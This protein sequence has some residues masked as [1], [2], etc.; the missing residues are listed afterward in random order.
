MTVSVQRNIYDLGRRCLGILA[1]GFAA[2]SC[3]GSDGAA[4]P[5]GPAG[6]AGAA[7]AAGA[8][9]QNCTVA[10]NGDGTYDV[11]CGGT[12]VTL[13]DGSAG[14]GCMITDNGDGTHLVSC[15]ADT[16][17][18]SD[19]PDPETVAGILEKLDQAANVEPESCAVCHSNAVDL[20]Q[21]IYNQY[22]DESELSLAITGVASSANPVCV[23]KTC[24]VGTECKDGSC[25]TGRCDGED[26]CSD[27][28]CDSDGLG[29]FACMNEYS[30]TVTF[31]IKKN[32]LP[33][34]DIAGLPTLEQK[35]F[36]TAH[37]D[38]TRFD[39]GNKAFG[40]YTPTATLGEYTATAGVNASSGP[41]PWDPA[42][43]DAF[44]YGYIADN[45]LDT[46]SGGHVSMYD[47]VA[48]ASFTNNVTGIANY[49]S[50]ANVA[51]C[52]KCHGTPYMKHG[53]RDPVV[54]GLGDFVSCK[55]CHYDTRNGGHQDW[56]LLVDKPADFVANGVTA[57]DRIDYAY[58]ATVMNDTHMAH[59]MEFPYP[60]SIANCVTCHEGK[61]ETLLVDA[62]FTRETCKSCHPLTGDPDHPSPAPAMKTIWAKAGVD[63]IHTQYTTF[64]NPASQEC[65]FCHKGTAPTTM[66][67]LHNGGYNPL[68]FS[69]DGAERFSEVFVTT[70]DQAS[71]DPATHVLNVKFSNTETGGAATIAALDADDMVP[72]LLIGL[73]GY[74]TKDFIV[75]AHDRDT[76]RNR[77]LEFQIDGVT[78]N[79]RF[80]V[81]SAA[82]AT[83]DVDVDLS[84]WA[85]MLGDGVIRRAEIAVEPTMSYVVGDPDISVGTCDPEC[86]RTEYCSSSDTCVEEDDRVIAVTASSRTFDL[87]ANTFDDDFYEDIVDVEKCNDCHE[88]LATTFHEANR[89]GNIRVC[90]M[91]HVGLSGGSHLEMQSRSIDSYVHAIHSF[92][93]FDVG[94]ID[95]SDPVE[96]LHY[97]QHIEHVFPNFTV[98]NCESCH[99][100]GK[101]GV[102]DQSKSLPG[103]LSGSDTVAGR[104]IPEIPAYTTGPA[105]RAC[106]ACHRAQMINENDGGKLIAFFQH[107]KTGGYLVEDET[108]VLDTVIAKIMSLFE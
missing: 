39:N 88:S 66:A 27:G 48:S 28:V 11:T 107:T 42:G 35:R 2:A 76:D 83:W 87:T 53:Y 57:Q 97:D 98:K 34:V 21:G 60:Q 17:T 102:P 89:S 32:G 41:I 22:N 31:T 65:N 5:T 92:Q 104:S 47:D 70:I 51:G 55:G 36:V 9:G 95:F 84:M 58:K 38:G 16:A 20:H 91:C 56:Q 73:Y 37:W 18:I 62:N 101:Y 46:E 75:G 15:G 93:P 100:A 103:K 68:V 79:P 24:T 12:T 1:I 50:P 61:L 4:G 14:A 67:T 7:G 94:D 45:L 43:V 44:V 6:P 40:D 13:T 54:A 78:T 81:N 74:D 8:A 108:G 80:T 3:S 49:A 52:E 25:D 33:F 26:P 85:G 30:A 96:K 64:T 105:T 63:T 72:T 82:G 71:Y 19:G 99:L 86:G 77:L 23:V 59:A 90:R 29:G 106:G 10:N 69:E